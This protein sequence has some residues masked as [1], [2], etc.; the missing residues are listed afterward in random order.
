MFQ[1]YT[2][3]PWSANWILNNL[4]IWHEPMIQSYTSTWSAL[5]LSRQYCLVMLV[6]RYFVL[7]GVNWPWLVCPI[8]KLYTINQAMMHDFVHVVQGR[9]SMVTMKKEL[10]GFLYPCMDVVLFRFRF[11]FYYFTLFTKLK[12]YYKLFTDYIYM[13]G[14]LLGS[15]TSSKIIHGLLWCRWNGVAE[16]PVG[17]LFSEAHERYFLR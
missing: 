3:N 7:T 12:Q 15:P 10:H 4:F 11:R 6:S 8:S 17:F 16:P 5:C 14:A 2:F 13:Y 9:R 1:F